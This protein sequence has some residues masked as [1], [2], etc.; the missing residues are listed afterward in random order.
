[1]TEQEWEYIP[2]EAFLY[3]PAG[4]EVKSGSEEKQWRKIFEGGMEY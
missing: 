4:E 1:M 3:F 2:R